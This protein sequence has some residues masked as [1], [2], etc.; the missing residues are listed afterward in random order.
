MKLKDKM[1]EISAID[2]KTVFLFDEKNR[3]YIAFFVFISILKGVSSMMYMALISNRHNA[4]K[5]LYYK[6][7]HVAIMVFETV[8]VIEI[9]L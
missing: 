7:T 5:I 8:H 2:F 1:D 9:I 3:L 6:E 4:Q